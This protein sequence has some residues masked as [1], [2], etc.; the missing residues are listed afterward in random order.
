MSEGMK[1]VT[2]FSIFHFKLHQMNQTGQPQQQQQH[3][4]MP[5]QP[6]NNNSQL[7]PVS[8]NATNPLSTQNCI[9][10]GCTNPAVCSIDWEDEYCSNECVTSH[11]RDV[12][13]NWVHNQGAQQ[14]QTISTVK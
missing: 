4:T 10:S 2:D 3:Q 5:S 13:A 8:G 14:Q 9:R 12:F 1:L 7:P 11:C 6:L